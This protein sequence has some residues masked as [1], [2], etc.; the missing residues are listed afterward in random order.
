MPVSAC[1]S[2]AASSSIS[3]V[4]IRIV[5]RLDEC[6]TVPNKQQQH[7]AVHVADSGEQAVSRCAFSSLLY[8]ILGRNGD[9][10]W[11]CLEQR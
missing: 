6:G 8:G 2:L 3:I 9:P 7:L 5:A 11:I 1:I 10:G 4:K